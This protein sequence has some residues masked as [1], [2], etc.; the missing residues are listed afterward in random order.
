MAAR[1][2]AL[3]TDWTAPVDANRHW[4]SCHEPR[5]IDAFALVADNSFHGSSSVTPVTVSKTTSRRNSIDSSH[6]VMKCSDHEVSTGAEEF[7]DDMFDSD[8][9]D[10]YLSDEEIKDSPAIQHSRKT[11]QRNISETSFDA[12]CLEDVRAAFEDTDRGSDVPSST[13]EDFAILQMTPRTQI[14]FITKRKKEALVAGM[15]L[16]PLEDLDR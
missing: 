1:K 7:A 3:I 5:S 9:E 14:K 8:A 10:E 4:S 6:R 11:V 15:G 12:F 2:K 16:S 13:S